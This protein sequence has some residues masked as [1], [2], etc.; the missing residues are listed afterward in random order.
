MLALRR[1]FL[2]APWISILVGCVASTPRYPHRAVLWVDPDHLSFGPRPASRAIHDWQSVDDLVFRPLAELAWPE[3]PRAAINVNALDE[4]PRSSWFVNR[5]GLRA[6]SPA[7]VARGACATDAPPPVPWRVTAAKLEGAHPGFFIEAADGT[8]HLLK[9]DGPLQPEHNTAADAIGAAIF[10]ASGYHVPCNRVAYVARD[11]IVLEPS[12]SLDEADLVRVLAA[13]GR[14]DEGRYRVGL[15]QLVEGT[16]LGPWSYGGVWDADPNDVV[17][18]EHRREL[19]GLFLL[20]AWIGHF[21]VRD[22]NTLATWIPTGPRAG[23]VRHWRIDFDDALGILAHDPRVAPRLGHQHWVDFEAALVDLLTLGLLERGWHHAG[24][25]ERAGLTLGYFTDA[26]FDPVSW[27][28]AVPTPAFERRT[29]HDLAWMARILARFTDAHLRALV[30]LG[31]FTDPNVPAELERILRARR[32]RI[33]ERYLARASPLTAPS[34]RASADGSVDLCLTD[35]A[36]LAGVRWASHRTYAAHAYVGERFEPIPIGA[37]RP[38]GDGSVCVPMPSVQS[39]SPRYLVV[40]VLARSPGTA[41]AG[42]AR[43]H[44]YATSS[45]RYDL[46]GLA[47][48]LGPEPPVP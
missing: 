1:R 24:I 6:L 31:R 2:L 39:A 30:E 35:L 17:P 8:R 14:D 7:R 21:D 25:H 10:H 43:L 23:Y 45:G 47:R 4:V 3:L 16:P 13:A 33:L 19:R 48:P 26:H 9:T 37:P 20:A 36:A 29:E 38:R 18:H 5:I 32:A 28:P 27:R 46:V 42:P 11:D 40:D 41:P 22:A 12:A 34:V 15:S 44:F